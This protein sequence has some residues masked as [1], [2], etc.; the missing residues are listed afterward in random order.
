MPIARARSFGENKNKIFEKAGKDHRSQQPIS[1][2]RYKKN[3]KER[4][5]KKVPTSIHEYL[6]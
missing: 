3:E 5:I 6:T 2:A 1:S 4:K